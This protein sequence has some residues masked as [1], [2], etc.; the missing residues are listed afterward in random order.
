[1][2]A[3][4][5]TKEEVITEANTEAINFRVPTS[6]KAEAKI[7]MQYLKYAGYG[8]MFRAF[9]RRESQ[10]VFNST[11]FKLWLKL[12]EDDKDFQLDK[13]KAKAKKLGYELQRIDQRVLSE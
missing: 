10:E 3:T 13:I 6:M 4:Q 2:S 7:L 1:M 9:Y 5:V 8:E 12:M 11:G